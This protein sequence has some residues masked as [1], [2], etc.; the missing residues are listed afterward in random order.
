VSVDDQYLKFKTANFLRNLESPAKSAIDVKPLQKITA[1]ALFYFFSNQYDK[2]SIQHIANVNAFFAIFSEN[3]GAFMA[4]ATIL[5]AVEARE[6]KALDVIKENLARLMA[7]CKTENFALN[8]LEAAVANNLSLVS[9]FS[10][11]RACCQESYEVENG[12]TFLRFT[13]GKHSFFLVQYISSADGLY[14]PIENVL[15]SFGHVNESHLKRLQ[16]KLIKLFPDVVAYAKSTNVFFGALVSHSRPGHFYYENWPVLVE[17][18]NRPGLYQK[19]PAV[20]MRKGHNFNDLDLLFEH[21]NHLLLDPGE[22]DTIALQQN[23]WLVSV[24]TNRNLRRNDACYELADRY[25]VDKVVGSPS[26]LAVEK[27]KQV[28]DCYPLVWIG[29]EGQKRCWLEQVEGYTHILNE[30]FKRYPRLGVVIDGW[31]VSFTVSEQALEEA[32]KDR[33]IAEKIQ[34]GLVAEIPVIFVMGENSNTKIYVGSKI[35]FFICNFATGSLYVSRILGKP[36]FCHLSAE[37]SSASLRF[38]IQVHPNNNVFLLP[39]KYV[40][41]QHDADLSYFKTVKKHL[42]NAVKSLLG[43]KKA[44]KKTSMKLGL[45]SYSID[46][47]D[48]YQFIEQRLDKVLGKTENK[49]LR[50]F[51]EPAFSIHH[52]VRSYLKIASYGNILTVFPTQAPPKKLRDLTAFTESYL[53]NHIIYGQFRFGGHTLLK[54]PGEYMVWLDD[55]LRRVRLQLQQLVKNAAGKN[56]PVDICSILKAGHKELDNHY[57]RL[58][59]G[60]MNVPFGKCSEK[61]LD[62]AIDNLTKHFVFIGI[63]EQQTHSFD[64]LCALMDWDRALFPDELPNQF[65]LESPD[66]LAHEEQ[67]INELIQYDVRLYNAALAM[68]DG[69]RA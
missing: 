29:V 10:D 22:I 26:E 14:F 62:T 40:T 7:D 46:K 24:G 11:N 15:I 28:S 52:S 67:L 35:D 68:I 32:N 51:I 9:P 6:T 45:I 43:K 63:N 30:L 53:K 66:L 55:P 56:Q 57:T 18:N 50:F 59:S 64:R 37:S 31:T 65:H 17:I 23:R 61:M 42:A 47:K 16:A 36:G 27:A 12:L 69:H 38:G 5:N 1:E 13:D 19:T 49:K 58:I 48:F 25:L 4:R 8:L 54:M 33:L 41:D 20:I 3:V 2:I 21:S 44:V 34:A 39:A 60:T